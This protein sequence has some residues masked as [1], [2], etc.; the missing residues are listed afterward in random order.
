[1]GVAFGA[2]QHDWSYRATREYDG[3]GEK[4][5]TI[6]FPDF[7]ISSLQGS[8]FCQLDL[9]PGVKVSAAFS[10]GSGKA[11]VFH[12]QLVGLYYGIVGTPPRRKEHR[13]ERCDVDVS[14]QPCRMGNATFGPWFAT[15][16]GWEKGAIV[17]AAQLLGLLGADGNNAPSLDYNEHHSSGTLGVACKIEPS[18]GIFCEGRFGVRSGLNGEKTVA[19]RGS[20][21]SS[22]TTALYERLPLEAVGTLS[23]R[24]K[25]TDHWSVAASCEGSR[26]SQKAHSIASNVTFSH[27][28]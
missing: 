23:V 5:N 24:G 28:F 21:E 15:S 20:G 4:F 13:A 8:V 11:S 25:I 27:E 16:L 2:V 6:F 14:I 7:E 18:P 3:S 9:S 10:A 19:C 22:S 1:M 17:D 12:P 26:G